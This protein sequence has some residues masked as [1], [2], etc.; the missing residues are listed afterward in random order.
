MT[1]EQWCGVIDMLESE[2]AEANK[3]GILYAFADE[4]FP[5]YFQCHCKTTQQKNYFHEIEYYKGHEIPA[6]GYS[7]LVMNWFVDQVKS[8]VFIL[9]SNL[10]DDIC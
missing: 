9:E 2:D 8:Y 4:D 6:K 5:F 10:K 3:I 7:K 1:K